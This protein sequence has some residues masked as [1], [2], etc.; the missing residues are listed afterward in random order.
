MRCNVTLCNLT[1]Y[2][3][4]VES[5]KIWFSLC[6]PLYGCNTLM[7]S[8]RYL[9]KFCNN[10][11][12]I[13]YSSTRATPSKIWRSSKVIRKSLPGYCSIQTQK[14]IQQVRYIL[15][16]LYAGIGGHILLET[17][18]YQNIN[19]KYVVLIHDR[20]YLV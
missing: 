17:K 14:R 5:L 12:S 20:K 13:N 6:K 7:L 1:M 19:V 15:S 9:I 3:N 2:V 11:H 4:R 8:Y 10:S 18:V 16:I